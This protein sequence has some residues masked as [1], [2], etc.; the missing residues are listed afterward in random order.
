MLGQFSHWRFLLFL[1]IS[2][3][4]PPPKTLSFSR[5]PPNLS[6]K[7]DDLRLIHRWIIVKFE[8]H[9]QNAS[10]N[11]ITVGN[12]LKMSEWREN[13]FYRNFFLF[14][15]KPKTILVKLRSW[16]LLPLDCHAIVICGPR[17]KF[18]RLYRWDL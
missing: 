13:P 15:Q 2:F 4:P 11:I 8:H 10:M 18:T 14:A 3:S 16:F 6:L 9:G 5:I 17:F 1:L 7:N 12:F